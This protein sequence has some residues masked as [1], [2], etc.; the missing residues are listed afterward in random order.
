MQAGCRTKLFIIRITNTACGEGEGTG[1]A[2]GVAG[3]Q[4]ASVNI[5]ERSAD[6]GGRER[7]QGEGRTQWRNAITTSLFATN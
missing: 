5:P 4:L 2:S 3:G 6:E 1:G 7:V